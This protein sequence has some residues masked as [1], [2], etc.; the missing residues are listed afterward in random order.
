MADTRAATRFKG[1]TSKLR[2]GAARVTDASGTTD[3]ERASVREAAASTNATNLWA[4]S[5]AKSTLRIMAPPLNTGRIFP[6]KLP[7]LR[8][9]SPATVVSAL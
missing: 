7:P 6:G 8:A 3:T 5:C 1:C 9:S 2:A 4:T